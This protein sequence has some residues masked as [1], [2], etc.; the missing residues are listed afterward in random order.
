MRFTRLFA[1]TAGLFCCLVA[2]AELINIQDSIEA[3][4]IKVTVYGPGD[5]YVLARSCAN[6]PFTRL[7]ITPGT[8]VW[9]NGA[10]APAD[11]RIERN[12]S[13]GAVIFDAKTKQ[14]VR[15]RIF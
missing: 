11:K 1:L 5:G 9:V 8:A 3:S 7:E 2:K 14:V 12:W 15:L 13:G 10:P 6:C 4:D